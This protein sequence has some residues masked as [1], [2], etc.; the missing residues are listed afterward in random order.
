MPLF[1]TAHH[2]ETSLSLLPKHT[3]TKLF[4]KTL[5]GI[6][7]LEHFF[8]AKPFFARNLSLF[9]STIMFSYIG[10]THNTAFVVVVVFLS[11]VLLIRIVVVVVVVV[12]FVITVF[13]II[14]RPCLI[15]PRAVP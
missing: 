5:L 13:D 2:T 1:F 15:P 10:K 14:Y 8:P 9:A 4:P 6:P 11:V 12:P 3:D 7:F